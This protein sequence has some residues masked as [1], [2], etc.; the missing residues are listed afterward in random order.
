MGKAQIIG[1]QTYNYV[2][3]SMGS[4]SL[5]DQHSS[6]QNIFQYFVLPKRSNA[7]LVHSE[8]S[9]THRHKNSVN[10]SIIRFLAGKGELILF[11]YHTPLQEDFSS[12]EAD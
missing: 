12:Q 4:K 1:K 7:H 9:N 2:Q 10:C 6:T 11:F 5:L 8:K 3:Y